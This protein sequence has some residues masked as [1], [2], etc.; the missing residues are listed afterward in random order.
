MGRKQA[1]V[2]SVLS[3]EK[4]LVSPA[5]IKNLFNFLKICKKANHSAHP[6]K[7]ATIPEINTLVKIIKLVLRQRL[8]LRE[9]RLKKLKKYKTV[10]RKLVQTHNKDNLM[11]KKLVN[12]SG[13]GILSL[14]PLI[15]GVLS[16]IFTK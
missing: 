12:Q 8:P 5:D 13:S 16:S 7:N 14:L 4:R 6:F 15:G 10:F 2:S 3:R 9:E 11:K 1:K